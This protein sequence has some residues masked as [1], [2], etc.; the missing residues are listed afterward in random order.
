MAR[1]ARPFPF[2]NVEPV[3]SSAEDLR[4]TVR[5][6]EKLCGFALERSAHTNARGLPRRLNFAAHPLA[7]L[8][9]SPPPRRAKRP[10]PPELPAPPPP[11]V[12]RKRKVKH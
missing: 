10:A 7:G 8:L 3:V 5:I 6:Y 11:R 1:R 4:K 9:P 2:G 12:P